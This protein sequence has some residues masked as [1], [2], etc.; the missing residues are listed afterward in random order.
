MLHMVLLFAQFD[1]NNN[2][3]LSQAK[4]RGNI[5]NNLKII[6]IK[7]IAHFTQLFEK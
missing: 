6:C 2:S 3:T 4:P 1:Q 7:F 5:P